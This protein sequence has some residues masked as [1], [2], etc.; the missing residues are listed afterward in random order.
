MDA[1]LPPLTTFILASGGKASA[2]LHCCR[3]VAR[4]AERAV[5]PLLQS[6]AI[7]RAAYTYI[8]RL[9]DYFF[10]AA[11]YAALHDGN[12]E[13]IYSPPARK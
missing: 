4:R 9:S 11:R 2:S 13:V 10:A 12:D 8:N 1:A 7:D 6:G 3:S 5:V